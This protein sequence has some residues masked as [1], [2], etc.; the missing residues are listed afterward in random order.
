MQQQQQFTATTTTQQ[1]RQRQ[2][3]KKTSPAEKA[4]V[5]QL[6]NSDVTSH[7]K[8]TQRLKIRN[9]GGLKCKMIT[10]AR[11]NRAKIHDSE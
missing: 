4:E 8:G 2:S 9:E 5:N 6:F 11:A 1:Q 7:F 3:P 10:V